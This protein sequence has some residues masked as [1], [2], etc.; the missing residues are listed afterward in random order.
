MADAPK[1]HGLDYDV[2]ALDTFVLALSAVSAA[3]RIRQTQPRG[4]W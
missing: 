1:E 3:Q 4:E 2:E